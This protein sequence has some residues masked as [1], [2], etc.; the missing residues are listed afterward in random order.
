[1]LLTMYNMHSHPDRYTRG[2]IVGEMEVN[3]D[4][5][6]PSLPEHV[7][8]L[9]TPGNFETEYFDGI[10][11]VPRKSISAAFDLTIA[12]VGAT[13]T[14]SDLPIPCALMVNAEFVEV[15]DGSLELELGFQGAHIVEAIE[16][17]YEMKR[18][19]V[20]AT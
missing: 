2:A 5:V 14:L 4:D 1:M 19:V 3:T 10:D 8:V 6:L 11:F 7:S 12:P 15:N 17:E 20:Y 18:W 16:T 13:V 9:H